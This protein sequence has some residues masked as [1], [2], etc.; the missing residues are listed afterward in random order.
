MQRRIGAVVGIARPRA[1]RG[2]FASRG[3]DRLIEHRLKRVKHG[4]RGTD[5]ITRRADEVVER[6]TPA[7]VG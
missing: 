7:V 1:S 2:A 6:A 3:I 5:Q 4:P